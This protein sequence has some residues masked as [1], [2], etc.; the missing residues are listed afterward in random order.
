MIKTFNI[1]EVPV[2]INSALG[3]HVVYR[4][5]FG[6]DVTNDMMELL[7]AIL[8]FLHDIY[9]EDDAINVFEKLDD[10]TI[11]RLV[12]ALS[13]FE[14]LKLIQNI[15]W[16]M[17]KNADEETPDIQTWLNGFDIFP[18]DTVA[19]D[20]FKEIIKTSVSSKNSSRL[21][22]KIDERTKSQSVQ[23]LSLEQAEV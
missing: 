16:A 22:K 2:K 20:L 7:D 18:L 5:E 10:E 19:V 9:D 17:A 11:S 23:S 1:G 6:H 21:L 15:L 12:I 14:P 8:G 3:W 13:T 4:E